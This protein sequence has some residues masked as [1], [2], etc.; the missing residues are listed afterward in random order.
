MLL[1]I[2]LK[3]NDEKTER[4][5]VYSFEIEKENLCL[6]LLLFNYIYIHAVH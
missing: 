4:E 3:N 5:R 6:D 1:I 2:L